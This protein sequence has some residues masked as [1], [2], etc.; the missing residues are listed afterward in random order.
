VLLSIADLLTYFVFGDLEVGCLQTMD[1][2]SVGVLHDNVKDDELRAGVQDSR[3][4]A[5]RRHGLLT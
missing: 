4:W 2:L 3:V 5:G 1:G